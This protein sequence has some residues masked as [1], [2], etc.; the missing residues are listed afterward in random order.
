MEQLTAFTYHQPYIFLALTFA[1]GAVVGSFLN[2]VVYR[3]PLGMNLIHP[4]SRCPNCGHAIRWHD[5]IPI[6]GWLILRGRCRDCRAPFSARYPLVELLTGLI[7]VAFCWIDLV[8]P[9]QATFNAVLAAMFNNQPEPDPHTQQHLAQLLYHLLILCPLLAAALIDADG[10]HV[11]RQLITWPA[12][13]GILL[14][15]GFPTAQALS[16]NFADHTSSDLASLWALV[17]SLIGLV[18]AV[19]IRL[20]MF[21]FIGYQRPREIGLLGATLA[22][23]AVGAFLGWQAAV[24]IGLIAVLWS[25]TQSGALQKSLGRLHPTAVV[26]IAALVWCV[27]ERSIARLI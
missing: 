16:I 19:F 26:F 22:L 6:L 13:T 17:N 15:F 21:H 4:G 25:L 27:F 1:V 8:A 7:F 23:Y 12:A 2:V 18:A 5:N 14:A 9:M 11:P 3:L 10:H 20:I 24:A